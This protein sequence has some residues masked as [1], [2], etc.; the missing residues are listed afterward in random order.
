MDGR[1]DRRTDGQICYIN[2]AHQHTALLTRDKNGVG[3]DD[4]KNLKIR[5]FVSTECTNVTDGWIPDDG[6]VRAYV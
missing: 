2:I 4:E 5:L 3:T 1:T 6:I